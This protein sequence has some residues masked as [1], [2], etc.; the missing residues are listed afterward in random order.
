MPKGGLE[1]QWCDAP[2]AEQTGRRGEVDELPGV[3]SL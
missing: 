1:T 2:G 3:P